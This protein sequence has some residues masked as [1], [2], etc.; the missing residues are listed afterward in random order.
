MPKGS[1]L[2]SRLFLTLSQMAKAYMPRS[3]VHHGRPVF[4]VEM[5]QNLGI[6]L[7]LEAMALVLQPAPQFP[8]IINLAVE[9]YPDGVIGSSHGLSAG[10]AQI[11]NR[12]TAMGQRHALDPAKPITRPHPVPGTAWLPE[13]SRSP[14]HP[15]EEPSA[16]M[17]IFLQCRTFT[18]SGCQSSLS[19]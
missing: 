4:P 14:P 13:S 15:P 11:N 5:E 10:L 2:S 8:I 19:S 7:G 1:R 16:D 6:A 12:E 3:R 17:Q 9:Y 18:L